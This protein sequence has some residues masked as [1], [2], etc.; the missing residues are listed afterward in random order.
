[1]KNIVAIV[2]RMV[3]FHVVVDHIICKMDAIVA[4]DACTNIRK[5]KEDDEPVSYTGKMMDG[6]RSF[7]IVLPNVAPYSHAL[8]V[9]L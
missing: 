7:P 2:Q 1:M 4:D 3:D 8:T 6:Q 9:D 5:S